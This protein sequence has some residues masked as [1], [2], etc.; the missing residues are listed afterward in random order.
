MTDSDADRRRVTGTGA[1]RPRHHDDESSTRACDRV[2]AQSNV[3]AVVFLVGLTVVG[4][5][6]VVTIG[7]GSLDESRRGAT[8][9]RV[10]QAMMSFTVQS[11]NV[12]LGESSRA[13]VDLGDGRGGRFVVSDDAGSIRVTHRNEDANGT[14][15]EIYR[16]TLGAVRYEHENTV[17]GYQAGGLWRGQGNSSVLISPPPI[18]YRDETLVMP[19]VR[20]F[21]DGDVTGP[22]RSVVRPGRTPVTHYPNASKQYG[23]DGPR[24]M[25]P[26]HEG[27][28]NVTIQSEFYKAWAQYF[29]TRSDGRLTLDHANRTVVL[30]LTA[31]GTIGPFE[32]PKEGNPIEIRGLADDHGL[33]NFTVVLAPDDTD[34]A[35]FD[36]LQWAMYVENG[37][38][39][40]EIHLRKS[41]ELTTGR[42]CNDEV[43]SMTLYYSDT[44]GNPYDGWQNETA[45][46]TE[47]TD[48]DGDGTDDETRIVANLTGSSPLSMRALSSTD[49]THFNPSGS[50]IRDPLTIDGHTASVAWEPATFNLSDDPTI[51]MGRVTRHY[52]SSIGSSF[53]LVVD[54]KD[55]NTVHEDASW[56]RLTYDGEGRVT[57]M[58]ITHREVRV[59][60]RG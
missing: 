13:A 10:E 41:G 6:L 20:A 55:S 2:R 36:N 30:E 59:D 38:R 24:Y 42:R 46:R 54:D 7:S 12:A 5:G 19:L 40:L 57:F 43:V 49:L 34:A 56:G 8:I 52:L 58:H 50:T 47:C 16:S 25:N 37:A 39:E 17:V 1:V 35:N 14:V 28:V 3:L 44:N 15:E 27:I 32:M 18:T 31:G 4:L 9:D 51:P 33:D 21:G 48:R 29:R 26:V 23:S 22:T 11:A 60:L 53:D 45:F